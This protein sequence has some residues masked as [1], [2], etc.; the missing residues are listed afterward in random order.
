MK[1]LSFTVF[2]LLFC[3][4]FINIQLQFAAD[5]S[6]GKV[7]NFAKKG[8]DEKNPS[9][10][11]VKK[12]TALWQQ[13]S[14]DLLK[15]ET[16][17]LPDPEKYLVFRLNKTALTQLLAD[18][19]SELKNVLPETSL[20]MELPM[21]DGTFARVRIEESSVLEPDLAARFPEI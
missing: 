4:L 13:V 17:G 15:S 8:I 5:F 7:K 11:K 9:S 16:H 2:A 6:E 1:K 14:E 3:L 12:Q 21:P 20:I 10:K 18:V 19:P